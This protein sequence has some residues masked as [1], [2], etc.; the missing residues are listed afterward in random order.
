MNPIIFLYLL[1]MIFPAYIANAIPV[2]AGGGGSI[3]FNIKF[4]DGRRLLG[5]GKT[6]RGTFW[7]IAA[8]FITGIVLIFVLPTM[9]FP[10]YDFSTKLLI[11]FLLSFGALFGD[12]AGSFLKRRFGFKDGQQAEY[13]DQLS[14]LAGSLLFTYSYFPLTPINLVFLIIFSYLIHK[15]TNLIAHRLNLKKVPW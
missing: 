10:L 14:F 6:I 5:K 13:L 12:S 8:G 11:S 15:I 9:F 2:I 4:L 3:D 7:G 1:V